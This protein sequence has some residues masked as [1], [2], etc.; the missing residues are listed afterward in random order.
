MKKSR[1]VF[2]NFWIRLLAFAIDF[3]ILTVITSV[4][5][6]VLVSFDIRVDFNKKIMNVER[7][8]KMGGEQFAVSVNEGLKQLE[9]A[10]RNLPEEAKS[11]DFNKLAWII[12]CIYSTVLV[13][14][15][16]QGTFGKQICGIMVI[17]NKYGR[18]TYLSAFTRF[19]A[20]TL[21]N[22]TFGIGFIPVLFTKEGISM[23]DFLCNT[24]VVRVK[25][26]D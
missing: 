25:I 6:S 8:E 4:A 7:L 14:S 2:A 5:V 24:R 26:G 21:T 16:K 23:H 12:S 13:A 11:I 18:T 15:K 22:M 17:D 10:Q 1:L 20:K 19:V 3:A 9:E